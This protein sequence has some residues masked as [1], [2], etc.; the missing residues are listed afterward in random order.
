MSNFRLRK[1]N[2]RLRKKLS[3]ARIRH[4]RQLRLETAVIRGNCAAAIEKWQYAFASLEYDMQW[5]AA[6]ECRY[7]GTRR[8][9]HTRSRGQRLRL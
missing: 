7:D 2:Q 1:D 3:A 5:N 6:N 9:C 8:L 4:R